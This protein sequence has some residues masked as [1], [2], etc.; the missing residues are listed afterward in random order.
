MDELRVEFGM[1]EI[2]RFRLWSNLLVKNKHSKSLYICAYRQE[3]VKI[4]M[5]NML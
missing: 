1:K 4:K 3:K 2:I 5:N